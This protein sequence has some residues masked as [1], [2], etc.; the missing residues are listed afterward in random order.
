M[1][2]E[3]RYG[4]ETEMKSDIRIA[5][6]TLEKCKKHLE[7]EE[8]MMKD[9][10]PIYGDGFRMVLDYYNRYGWDGVRQHIQQYKVQ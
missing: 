6:E 1:C 8:N 4:K 7:N 3:I 10:D 9:S 5:A 2:T